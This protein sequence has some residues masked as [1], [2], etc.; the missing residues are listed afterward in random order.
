MEYYILPSFSI[1]KTK[2]PRWFISNPGILFS[3]VEASYSLLLYYFPFK[4]INTK[5]KGCISNGSKCNGLLR[6][7]DVARLWN[8]SQG[9]VSSTC[10][11]TAKSDVKIQKTEINANLLLKV[12]WEK[13]G[14]L[15]KLPQR[16][17][18]GQSVPRHET[19]K[20]SLLSLPPQARH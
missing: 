10:G 11:H 15:S 3:Q 20:T 9:R 13:K 17:F 18:P 6:H 2:S 14:E 7:A 19:A 1:G 4:T 8:F 16:P 12:I 5:L